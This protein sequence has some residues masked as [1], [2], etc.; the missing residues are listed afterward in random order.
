MAI[1]LN[2]LAKK[3]EEIAIDSGKIT[4]LSS[5]TV[6]LYDISAEWR[7]LVDASKYR[8]ANIPEWSEREEEAAGV[9][10]ATI[11]YLK[12]IGCEDIERLI[13]DKLE[14][15]GRKTM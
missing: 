4:P 8:S 12:R 1:T 5:P 15:A 6:S 14:D 10:I 13:K 11:T 7:S 3:C 2:K 9:I